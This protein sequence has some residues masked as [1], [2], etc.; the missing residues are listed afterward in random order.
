VT[1]HPD[2]L[3]GLAGV[4]LATDRPCQH[5]EGDLLDKPGNPDLLR[6]GIVIAGHRKDQIPHGVITGRAW[7]CPHRLSRR[8]HR[9]RKMLVTQCVSA[10]VGHEVRHCRRRIA[11][12]PTARRWYWVRTG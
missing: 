10:R 7:L 1:G 8:G 2:V 9:V 6:S 11:T 5:T 3:N 4:E 12:T